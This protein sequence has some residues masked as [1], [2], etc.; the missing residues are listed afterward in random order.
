MAQIA[1]RLITSPALASSSRTVEPTELGWLHSTRG[2]R[3]DWKVCVCSVTQSCPTLCDHMDHSLPGSS[4]HEIL[5]ARI[6]EWVPCPPPGDLPNPGIEPRSP[7]L[8]TD[9]L[10]LSHQKP[11]NTR[12]G[13][14]CLLQGSSWPRNQTRISGIAGGFLTSWATR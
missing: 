5:H 6:L 13:S 9:S 4:V 7:V 14:L 10:P 1:L 8:Q 3:G 11:M 2:Q 12:V